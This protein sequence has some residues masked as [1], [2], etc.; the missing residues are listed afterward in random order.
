MEKVKFKLNEEIQEYNLPTKWSEIKLWQFSEIM[1]LNEKLNLDDERDK[2]IA[3]INI[4]SVLLDCEDELIRKMS[5]EQFHEL[6]SKINFVSE[7]LPTG[8]LPQNFTLN[9]KRYRFDSALNKMS[10]GQFVD[11]DMMLKNSNQWK[12]LHQIVACLFREEKEV[13]GILN[14]LKRK[15]NKEYTI[16]EYSIETKNKRAELFKKELGI[17][18][19]YSICLFFWAFVIEFTQSSL[20]GYSEKVQM[21]TN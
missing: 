19:G 7:T 8:V 10:M 17:D 16:E 3:G 15:K 6:S 14:K 13:P 12:N 11:L 4:L 1:Q 9:G 18:V 20:Q 5:I 2:N 21:E